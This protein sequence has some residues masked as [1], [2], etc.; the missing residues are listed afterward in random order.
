MSL[1]RKI[2]ERYVS[3]R[4]YSL[5]AIVKEYASRART[6][7]QQLDGEID[8]GIDMID[9]SDKRDHIYAKAGDRI[10]KIQSL[11][12]E[13][14]DCIHTL[15]YMS[16]RQEQRN[17]KNRIPAGTRDEIDQA[18]KHGA[19][20]ETIARQYAQDLEDGIDEGVQEASSMLPDADAPRHVPPNMKTDQ[21]SDEGDYDTTDVA[22]Q[23][24][25]DVGGPI[26]EVD[27]RD[28]V[29]VQDD[30]DKRNVTDWSDWDTSYIRP[31]VPDDVRHH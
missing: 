15:S 16:A 4:E 28:D 11:V 17:I 21:R 1:S 14:K 8:G 2:A 3:S 20:A 6:A 23:D 12:E 18:I 7:I 26:H 10:A 25:D 24:Q 5:N 19:R 30:D 31:N 13:L 29:M 22:D 27:R 9:D